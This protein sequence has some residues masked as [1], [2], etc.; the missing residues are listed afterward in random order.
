MRGDV[1]GQRWRD[2]LPHLLSDLGVALVVTGSDG[3]VVVNEAFCTMTG[4]S[5]DEALALR[6]FGEI[7]ALEAPEVI[8]QA[9][10]ALARYETEIVGRD[11]RR[12]PVAVSAQVVGCDGRPEVVATFRDLTHDR[13]TEYEL[14]VR[15]RQQEVVAELG[16]EALVEGDPASLMDAAVVAVAHTLG[17]EYTEVLELRL[18]DD[19]LLLRAGAGWEEELVG[20]ATVPA[21]R[22]S[23]AGLA[24]DA[25]GP[26]VVPDL[27][28]ETRCA[29][30]PLLID[31][32]VVAGAFVVIRGVERP[33]GVLAAH[34]TQPRPFSRD[35]VHFLRAVANVLADAIG[36]AQAEAALRAAHDRERRLRQRLQAHSRRVVGAQESERR[37]IAHEL[38]DEIGQALTG[39]KMTL[40]DYD[41][42]PPASVR[43]RMARATE[44]TVDLLRR[45]HDL[46]LDLRPAMLDDLGLAPALVWLVERYTTQTGVEVALACSGLA[47][48]LDPQVETAA[49]RIVQE[50]LTNVAR[51]AGVKRAAVHCSVAGTALRVEVADEGVGFDVHAVPV[52]A[53]TGLVGMEERAR[54]TGGRLWVRSVPGRGATLVAHLPISGPE[55]AAP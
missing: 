35:D 41:D 45:L 28:R 1:D 34:A 29:V 8:A 51:H 36:Q 13:R 3:A 52:G 24:L 4:Y 2:R 10:P 55:R 12:I 53:S 54:S 15:A 30:P 38:H 49:Y 39:L 17:V 42:L 26:V 18:E 31:H 14:T 23:P 40:E 43:A 32:G 6:S 21:G 33:Y 5:T 25:D 11:G 50:A 9:P 16:R 46:S 22:G 37:R 27:E 44:L 19:A 47:A 48:R 7:V 20:K